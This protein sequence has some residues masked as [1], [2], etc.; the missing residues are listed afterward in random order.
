MVDQWAALVGAWV[1]TLWSESWTFLQSTWR[2]GDFGITYESLMIAFGI[3]L[4]ALILRG[5]FA[6][7]VIGGVR[8][9]TEG[10]ETRIDDAL[11][12]SLREPMKFVFLI[13]G[14]D[15]A[16]RSLDLAPDAQAAADRFVQ[17]LIAIAIF[18][19]LNRLA[20]VLRL[21]LEPL[22][23]V[24]TQAAVDWLVRALQIIF[25]VVG[26]AAVLEIWGVRVAP[27][28][29]GLGI[30][31]VA[32]ALGAQD[33]FRNL[34]AGML[35]LA[36][37]RFGP[38]DW[39]L[40]EGEVEGTVEQINFRSTVVRR[41]DKGPVYIPNSKL[42]DNAVVN[43]SRMTHRRIYWMIGVEYTTSVEQLRRIRDEIEAYV[44]SHEA[45]SQP[46]ETPV[47]VRIDKFNDSSIDIM[48]YC[49]TKTTNWGEWL[50]IKEELAYAIKDIV[51]GAGT[52][53]AFPSRSVYMT[54][55]EGR[56]EP[57]P[58]PPPSAR[59]ESARAAGLIDR[60]AASRGEDADGGEG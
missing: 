36:E 38:G 2:D 27:L 20:G 26:L 5:L 39:I 14:V 10:T 48:L 8:K 1:Q 33:L 32:V 47:F 56:P 6:R 35:I 45:F 53:F 12:D 44:R 55:V 11:V 3:I 40:V 54:A 43:F 52:G 13:I 9:L 17:S 58:L 19:A 7:W 18:W 16:L 34:I 28:L 24:L 30:F 50:R 25:L 4:V 60:D 21:V 49:F 42:S 57:Y 15:L 59:L 41:F 51:E 23:R 22:A 46:P 31:G 37:K 29:A